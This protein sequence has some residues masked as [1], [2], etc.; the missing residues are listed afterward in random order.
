MSQVSFLS[1]S[2]IGENKL[3]KLSGIPLLLPLFRHHFLPSADSKAVYQRLRKHFLTP[4]PP[5]IIEGQLQE[6]SCDTL[7]DQ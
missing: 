1:L 7:G 5:D 2:S 3:V 6:V 4:L